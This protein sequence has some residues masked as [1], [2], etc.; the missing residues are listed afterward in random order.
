MNENESFRERLLKVITD[1]PGLHFRELQRRTGSAVGKLDY[2]LYQMERKGEIYSLKDA[3]M[4]RFFVTSED[5][6]L[7]RRIALHM[8][9][10]VSKEIILKTALAGEHELTVVENRTLQSLDKMKE[11]GI[12]SYKVDGVKAQVTLENKEELVR[13]LKKYRRSFIDSIAYSIFRMLDE[14]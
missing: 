4:V 9:N 7:E 6:V 8:R 11:D 2:H 10:Q 5:T 14:A 12:L 3:R 13:F 1:N